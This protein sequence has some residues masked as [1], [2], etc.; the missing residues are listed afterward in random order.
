VKRSSRLFY[1]I[2]P[3]QV[4]LEPAVIQLL[5]KVY[6]TLD[7]NRIYFFNGMPWFMKHAFAIGITLPGTYNLSGINIYLDGC[8]QRSTEGLC[9]I[10]HELFH[11]LQYKDLHGG[12]GISKYVVCRIT[13][14]GCCNTRICTAAMGLG[15]CG[16]FWCFTLRNISF[17]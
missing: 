3:K 14:L 4:P 15:F 1:S 12:Y 6:P 7:F 17:C 9:L 8:Y 5:S 16:H 13:C 10:V 2:F 11:G